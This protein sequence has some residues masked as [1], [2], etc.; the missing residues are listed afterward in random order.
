MSRRSTILK[1]LAAIACFTVGVTA[2]AVVVSGGNTVRL[3]ANQNTYLDADYFLTVNQVAGPDYDGTGIWLNKTDNFWSFQS[4]L[5]VVSYNVDE[6]AD[7]YL[8]SAGDVLSEHA[9]TQG[10]FEPLLR[11]SELGSVNVAYPG[12]FYL[13]IVTGVGWNGVSPNRN[14]YGWAKFHN[15]SLGLTLVDSAVAYGEAGIV[16]GSLTALVVPEASTWQLFVLGLVGL[17]FIAR[18][19]PS[20]GTPQKHTPCLVP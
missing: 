17:M 13:G 15:S 7:L 5:S 6:G 4:T 16:V 1:T 11:P 20:A 18:Q 9:L 3:T 10:L 8:V 12:T 14:V 2:Q 19:R